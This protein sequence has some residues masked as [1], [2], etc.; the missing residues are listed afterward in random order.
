M[1]SNTAPTTKTTKPRKPAPEIDPASLVDLPDNYPMNE[2]QAA[3]YVG[4]SVH[5]LRMWRFKGI[6]PEY[7]KLGSAVRYQ[8]G[9]LDAY[10]A[11]SSIRP[12]A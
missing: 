1:T 8:R 6:G 10:L 2:K 7:M 9:T 3:C 12:Q 11:Q 5:T 4:L